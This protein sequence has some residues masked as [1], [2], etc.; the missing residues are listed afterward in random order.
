MADIEITHE[1]TY[2]IPTWFIAKKNIPNCNGIWII[3][4]IIKQTDKAV[5]CTAVKD[6]K[7]TEYHF[8]V[9]KTILQPYTIGKKASC[10]VGKLSPGKKFT[11]LGGSRATTYD[12]ADTKNILRRVKALRLKGMVIKAIRSD[13]MIMSEPCELSCHNPNDDRFDAET[14][15]EV[16]CDYNPM[17]ATPRALEYFQ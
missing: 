11:I 13:R 5:E 2:Q 1:Q 6:D 14:N 8:W 10:E 15:Y 7:R 4:G 17:C 3:T 9:P 12:R 16:F